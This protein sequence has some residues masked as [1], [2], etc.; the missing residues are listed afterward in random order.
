MDDDTIQMVSMSDSL[1][2]ASLISRKQ[3]EE[4]GLPPLKAIFSNLKSRGIKS[5]LHMCDEMS[6]RLDLVSIAGASCVSLDAMVD[7]KKAKEGFRGRCS[8]AGNVSST[9]V[10][11]EKDS[12]AVRDATLK[13]IAIAAPGGG[14]VP[15]PAC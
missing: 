4:M 6:D 13:C 2:S 11:G 3:F 12:I 10:L 1:S 8:L 14:Y 15:M 9:A 7:M 5:L